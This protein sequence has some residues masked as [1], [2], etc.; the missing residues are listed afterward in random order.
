MGRKEGLF[1]FSAGFV[2]VLPFNTILTR[3]LA[4]GFMVLW[5]LE[6]IF[7]GGVKNLRSYRLIWVVV[8]FYLLHIL[9]LL[10][11]SNTGHALFDLE[12]KLT[13]LL[14]PFAFASLRPF[15]QKQHH[16][17]LWSFIAATLLVTLFNGVIFAGK[18]LDPDY[19]DY[20]MKYPLYKFYI[21]FSYF[22]HPTYYAVFLELSVIFLFYLRRRS[23]QPVS[24]VWMVLLVVVFTL[25]VFL[26]SSRAGIVSLMVIFVLTALMQARRWYIKMVLIGGLVAAAVA[27]SDNYRFSNYLELG[28]RLVSQG[29]VATNELIEKDALRIVLWDVS[30]D[31]STSHL[32]SGVGIGDITGE[33]NRE[34]VRRDILKHLEKAYNPHN[35]YLSTLLGLGLG[36]L[37]VLLALLVWPVIRA[38]RMGDY[39]VAAF[40]LLFMVHFIFEVMLN[41]IAG[42]LTFAFFYGFLIMNGWKKD[43]IS[44]K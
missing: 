44:S 17:V 25:V 22:S 37:L 40:I 42:V 18:L 12:R 32:W 34:Y 7:Q 30:L 6:M 41:R 27:G 3:Y 8:A 35:Q 19:Y 4:G 23:H 24:V 21:D 20:F 9:S 43:E 11:S 36:G 15:T 1:L 5:L 10:Y 33:L 38:I 26:I 16:Y 28:Q 31:L 39:L 13:L 2:F 29:Q 14:F